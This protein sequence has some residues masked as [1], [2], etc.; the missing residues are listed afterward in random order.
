MYIPC[1]SLLHVEVDEQFGMWE[2]PSIGEEKSYE[3][4]KHTTKVELCVI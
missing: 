1:F 4:E 2:A 3:G